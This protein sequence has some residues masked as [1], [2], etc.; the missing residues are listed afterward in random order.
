MPI[1]M[2]FPDITGQATTPSGDQGWIEVLS[3]SWGA[4][5]P[6]VVGGSGIRPGK[7]SVSDFSVEKTLDSASVEIFQKCV[8]GAK[9]T[10]V[11]IEFYKT[12]AA[13]K[14]LEFTLGNALITSYQLSG[15]SGVPTESISLAFV[16]IEMSYTSQIATNNTE[17]FGFAV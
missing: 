17:D 12:G 16:K 7:P 11:L 8:T 2:N 3:F 14:Y 13:A 6:A 9:E 1:F 15:S 10:P 4:S 5:A